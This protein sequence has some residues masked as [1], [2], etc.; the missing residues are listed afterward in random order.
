[1]QAPEARWRM[2]RMRRIMAHEVPLSGTDAARQLELTARYDA[3]AEQHEDDADVP[4]ETET[5]LAAVEQELDA[6]GVK[7]GVYRPDDIARAGAAISIGDDGTPRVA[8]G[9]FLPSGKQNKARDGFESGW[10]TSHR[11]RR[12]RRPAARTGAARR[13]SP[14]LLVPPCPRLPAAASATARPPRRH[15]RSRPCW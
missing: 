6:I 14:R 9:Y 4:D 1:L 7:E 10:R 13:S 11:P 15:T 12:R 3:L 5:E 8:R 2:R